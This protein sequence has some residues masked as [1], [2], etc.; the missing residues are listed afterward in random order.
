MV[1]ADRGVSQLMNDFQVEEIPQIPIRKRLRPCCAFGSDIQAKVGPIPVPFYRIPNLLGS[2]ELGKH[3]Y[4]SGILEARYGEGRRVGASEERNGLVYTCRGGFID[5]AHVRDYVDWTAFVATRIAATFEKGGT[6]ELGE[7]GGAKRLVV[8]P[9]DP[10]VIERI[11]WRRLAAWLS[12]WSGFQLSVWHE[13]ATWYGWAAVPGFSERASS[14]SPE[15]LYSNLIGAK[16]TMA[17]IHRRAARTEKLYNASVAAWME[18]V[19][20]HLGAVPASVGRDAAAAVDGLWWD[21]N[22]RVPDNRLV[23]RRNFDVGER[24]EPW[25]VPD[26]LAP[27]S[28]RA[29]CGGTPAPLGLSNPS[30]REEVDF[31]RWVTLEIEVGE[32]LAAHAPFAEIG[33]IVTHEEFPQLIEA[34]RSE[35]RDELGPHVDRRD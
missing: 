2:D 34:I 1:L 9:L 24:I 33:P 18:E 13:I 16:L 3:S 32:E 8:R 29:A 28:L 30:Q 26:A 7:E 35:A 10:D 6:I 17:I 27:P 5:T 15:D 4:D 31:G 23:L 19:L 20:E 22:A 25:L 12:R 21:S 11:G 14:F